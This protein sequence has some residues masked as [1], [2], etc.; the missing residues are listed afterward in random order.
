MAGGMTG[1]LTLAFALTFVVPFPRAAEY[2]TVSFAVLLSAGRAVFTSVP[3]ATEALPAVGA[4]A[5]VPVLVVAPG[6]VFA[7]PA[8]A[9]VLLVLLPLAGA[10]VAG[11]PF[12]LALFWLAVLTVDPLLAGVDG[13]PEF[14]F[15]VVPAGFEVAAAPLPGVCVAE[16]AGVGDGPALPVEPAVFCA[17]AIPVTADASARI[18]IS[19]ISIP[20]CL[21]HSYP[22]LYF[23]AGGGGGVASGSRL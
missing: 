21:A 10:A 23:F 18:C 7:V 20:L 22:G 13:V 8:A 14:D 15:V 11:E 17:T 3:V 6:G 5:T 9:K 12:A 1:L 2:V 16:A 19:F 4:A